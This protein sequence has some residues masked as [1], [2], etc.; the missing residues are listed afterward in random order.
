MV[1][2]VLVIAVQNAV[3]YEDLGVATSGA[4]LFRLIGGSLGTAVLGAIFAARLAADLARTLPA[5]EGA[6]IAA[7][8]S[9]MSASA[10]ARLPVPLRAAY[11]GAFTHALDTI[12]FVAVA[13]AV[14]GFLFTW[15]LPE[16]TLRG[17]VAA[18]AGDIGTESA[19]AFARP[20][21]ADSASELL[22]ALALV[23]DRDTQRQHI[24][25][26]VAR[27]GETRSA[28]AAWLLVTLERDPRTDPVGLGAA[29]AVSNQR[30]LDA[31]REL[32]ERRLI[33]VSRD[34]SGAATRELTTEGCA[35]LSRLVEARR[36]HLNDLLAEWP[37]ATR[38]QMAERLRQTRA[39][40][41]DVRQPDVRAAS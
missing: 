33:D 36:A 6:H 14:V 34:S 37:V 22:H 38:E 16:H 8:V 30:M 40:V 1:M 19:G 18:R 15:L 20:A 10:M 17:T 32:E 3:S 11:S 27:A 29:H 39:L 31:V 25:R 4:T 28:A 24:E 26:I 9:G 2:Q 7:G 5:S 12:F 21:G 35:V 23:A 41:P 13:V